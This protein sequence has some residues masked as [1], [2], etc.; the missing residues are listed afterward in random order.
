MN[1]QLQVNSMN[2]TLAIQLPDLPIENYKIVHA[3]IGR[4]RFRIP[5]FAQDSIY[6]QRLEDCVRSLEFVTEVRINRIVCSLI[7]CYETS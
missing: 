7:V 3:T 2:S 6:T 5:R 4:F 1:P